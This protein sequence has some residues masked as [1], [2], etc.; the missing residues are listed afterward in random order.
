MARAKYNNDKLTKQQ[1][2]FVN[3]LVKGN[4]QRQA[5]LKAYPSKKKWKEASLDC[6]ASKLFSNV[7]VKQRY[8]ELLYTMR[9]KEREKTMWTRDQSIETLRYVIDMNRKDMERISNAFED[10]L[11]I[12]QKLMKEDPKKAPQYLREI[13]KQQKS[14]RASRVNNKGITDAVAELNKM[15]GFNEETINLN[16]TVIFAE[17]DELED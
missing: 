5:Y 3:E 14:R 17:E 7:K 16:G 11:E 9:E 12:L 8:D 1:E 6:E 10:E 2:I 4:T 15:Q 13:L